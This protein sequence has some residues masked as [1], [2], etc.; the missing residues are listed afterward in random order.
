MLRKRAQ[1]V[2]ERRGL[3]EVAFC[4]RLLSSDDMGAA[5]GISSL[6]PQRR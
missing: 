5:S 3:Q 6:G 1:P 2:I 4:R